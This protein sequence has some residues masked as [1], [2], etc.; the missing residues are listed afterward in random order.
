MKIGPRINPS[1]VAVIEN[2]LYAI[3]TNR[4]YIG[5]AQVGIFLR[6]RICLGCSSDAVSA[7]AARTQ[8]AMRQMLISAI[9]PRQIQDAAMRMIDDSDNVDG[10]I[11]FSHAKGEF[12]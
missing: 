10:E 1:I 12:D 4:P 3:A 11:F 5:Q 6:T 7:F 9:A 2:Q 8:Q